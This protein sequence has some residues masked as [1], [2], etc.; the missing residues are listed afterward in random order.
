MPLGLRR[1]G[2]TFL[3]LTFDECLGLMAHLCDSQSSARTHKNTRD[4]QNVTVRIDQDNNNYKDSS[5][6]LSSPL[7]LD[8][9]FHLSLLVKA[10][11]DWVVGLTW[12]F[13]LNAMLWQTAITLIPF[14][15]SLP[16]RIYSCSVRSVAPTSK[17]PA[18]CAR[19]CQFSFKDGLYDV[20]AFTRPVWRSSANVPSKQCDRRQAGPPSFATGDAASI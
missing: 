13:V 10:S 3:S 6:G 11:A 5:A 16:G 15:G 14:L 17:A 18:Y 7:I 8:R 19:I 4:A 12:P 9:F 1:G 2:S 20:R